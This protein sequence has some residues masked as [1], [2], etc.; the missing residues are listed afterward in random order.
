MPAG[1]PGVGLIQLRLPLAG[2]AVAGGSEG[3]QDKVPV[4]LSGP[5]GS[6]DSGR[7]ALL[8]RLASA[9]VELNAGEGVAMSLSSRCRVPV[10][11]G[12]GRPDST[13]VPKPRLI[14]GPH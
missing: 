2:G 6:T 3:A 10:A 11:T 4:V 13:L 14:M 5:F 1:R 12:S 7:L 9:S 8:T